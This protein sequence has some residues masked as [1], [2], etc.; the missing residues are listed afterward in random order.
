MSFGQPL[1]NNGTEPTASFFQIFGQVVHRRERPCFS[2]MS[3]PVSL[4][5]PRF[6]PQRISVSPHGDALVV[7]QCTHIHAHARAHMHVNEHTQKSAH[8]HACMHACPHQHTGAHGR[9]GTHTCA[10]P[11]ACM[12]ARRHTQAHVRTDMRECN[13]TPSKRTCTCTCMC[14]AC[15]RAH[16]SAHV[17]AC[18]HACAPAFTHA[19]KHLHAH[20]CHR[21]AWDRLEMGTQ[22]LGPRIASLVGLWCVVSSKRL[23][24]HASMTV[25]GAG[26]LWCK[27]ALRHDWWGAV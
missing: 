17:F 10:G 4:D 19:R 16:S 9:L 26:T 13:H 24:A 2:R 21:M 15:A 22:S 12:H 8:A 6:R 7:G 18:A 25:V 27:V 3:K 5:G 14:N 23:S 11:C 20:L 1:A